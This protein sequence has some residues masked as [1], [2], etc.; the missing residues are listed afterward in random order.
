MEKFI[1]TTILAVSRDGKTAVGGDGQ[2]TMANTIIKDNAVKLR[3]LYNNRVVVGFAGAVADSFALMAK[4]EEKLESFN[5]N[6]TRAAVELTKEWRTSKI[7][8]R[9]ES[10]MI[11]ADKDTLLLISGNGEVIEP[12]DKIIGIGSG[13]TFATAAARAM[14]KFTDFDARRVVGESLK[15]TADMCIYTNESIQIEEIQ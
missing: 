11:A 14:M 15:I 10:L 1:G 13:G 4:F 3:R 6:V 2:V 7:L 5:G 9:L 8:Q 12:E